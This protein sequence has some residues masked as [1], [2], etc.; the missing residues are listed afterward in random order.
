MIQIATVGDT[1]VVVK[2]G[3]RKTPPEKLYILHTEN[4]RTKSKLTI[5]KNGFIINIKNAKLYLDCVNEKI[6]LSF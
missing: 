6:I 5:E 3:L 2:E 1:Q 4:E